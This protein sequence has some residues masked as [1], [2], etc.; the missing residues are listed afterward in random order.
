MNQ[1][2]SNV[3]DE[4]ACL[5]DMAISGR[6]SATTSLFIRA[7]LNNELNYLAKQGENDTELQDFLAKLKTV[8]PPSDEEPPKKR[9]RK[10]KQ[11]EEMIHDTEEQVVADAAGV[12]VEEVVEA[13]EE[14][15]YQQ[16][17]V[18]SPDGEHGLDP[19]IG[20]LSLSLD[21]VSTEDCVNN[22]FSP[23]VI[24]NTVEKT[25]PHPFFKAPL[26]YISYLPLER[27]KHYMADALGYQDFEFID[28]CDPDT[29]KDAWKAGIDIEFVATMLTDG[30]SPT[31]RPASK[32]V[33]EPGVAEKIKAAGG[34]KKITEPLGE[35]GEKLVKFMARYG[36]NQQLLVDILT[37][38]KKH[39]ENPNP[40][41]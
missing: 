26:S 8:P 19:R 17:E 9:G 37:I 10:P 12:Q 30:D 38:V 32:V 34:F 41:I 11:K 29:Q 16:L 18:L 6:V 35:D 1:R 39:S 5:F 3:M 21:Q 7:A 25:G 2:A 14:D 13:W 40:Y 4:L 15:H 33:N 20:R 31:L 23:L 22:G 28:F 27:M 36:I 24:A